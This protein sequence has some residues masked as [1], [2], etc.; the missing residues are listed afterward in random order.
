M[1][2]IN[3]FVSKTKAIIMTDG[4]G[5]T[6]DLVVRGFY[7]KCV[8][9]PHLNAAVAVRGASTLPA[10]LAMKLG[11]RF[12]TFD[13]LVEYGTDFLKAQFDEVQAELETAG[14]G[15]VEIF[16]AGWSP[17]RRAAE[18]YFISSR[19]HDSEGISAWELTPVLDRAFT[20][21]PNVDLLISKAP[22]VVH[23]KDFSPETH[24]RPLMELQRREMVRPLVNG[25]EANS[26]GSIVGGF[27]M[28]TTITERGVDQR[29]FHRWP[30]VLN[31]RIQPDA[32]PVVAI[33]TK[34]PFSSSPSVNAGMSRQQRRA[35]EAQAKKRKA[36]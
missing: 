28:A 31:E 29:V 14:L 34:T 4:A 7:S 13:E 18:A 36:S 22:A 20:P 15:D 21:W 8:A 10:H 35:A 26:A 17:A 25:E 2:A 11:Q 32:G 33:G 19:D 30:D 24:G 5:Y 27:A 16:L 9:I 3:V 1:T 12:A 23:T 6:A